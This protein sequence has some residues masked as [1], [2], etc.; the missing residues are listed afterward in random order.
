VK[1]NIINNN[2][3]PDSKAWYSLKPLQQYQHNN[4]APT[5]WGLA[6]SNYTKAKSYQANK[7]SWLFCDMPY[8]GRWNP[9]YQAVAPD[10]DY[11]WRTIVN[12]L[13]VNKIINGLP[14]DRIKN[15][16]I[17]EWRTTGDYILVAPSSP[18]MNRF[19]D[20]PNWEKDTI[21]F[22]KTKTDMPIRIRHKPRKGGKSGPAYAL[23][24]LEDDLK[25]ATCVVTGC[26][27]VA[28][29]AIIKG[30]PVYC[31]DIAS[32]RPVAQS[33]SNFGNPVYSAERKN[34]LATLSYHQYTSKE[35]KSGLFKEAIEGMYSE[36]R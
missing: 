32:T 27:L 10:N 14:H 36:M 16:T 13:H 30:I 20:T 28:V 21:K 19:M 12:G 34:W 31:H 2:H 4:G 3:G 24:P 18:T 6:G 5:L 11:Y 8:W 7:S 33:I 9:L 26:S 25:K 17:E 1:L 23:V 35:I 29:E 22:L 15:I